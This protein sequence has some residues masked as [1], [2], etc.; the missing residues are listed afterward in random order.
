M[1]RH[2]RNYVM[3]QYI[4]YVAAS[5]ILTLIAW[6]VSPK[7]N[8]KIA[9]TVLFGIYFLF[10]LIRMCLAMIKASS[11]FEKAEEMDGYFIENAVFT[12]K[13]IIAWY[14]HC[15]CR[16]RYSKIKEALHDRNLYQHIKM[17]MKGR[18][19]VSV[20]SEDTRLKVY[21]R[22][23]ECADKIMNLIWTKNSF[24]QL[25]YKSSENQTVQLSELKKYQ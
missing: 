12:E 6:F 18:S 9:M 15:I 8:Q 25:K 7:M 14:R 1:K 3:K 11:A 16:I 22:S 24:A 23:A 4:V 2:F 21:T 13:E 17:Q 5:F 19:S 10:N 20:V